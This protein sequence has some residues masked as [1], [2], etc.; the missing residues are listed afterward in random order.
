M[1]GY[2]KGVVEFNN[3][4]ISVEVKSLNSKQ[5]D[6]SLKMPAIYR[7]KEFEIR[8][9]ITK[10]LVRG[11]VE[12]YINIELLDQKQAL[13]INKELFEDYYLQLSSIS[14][15]INRN[16][17]FMQAILTLPGVLQNDRKDVEDAEWEALDKAVNIAIEEIDKFRIQE[18]NI[19]IR[20]MLKRISIIRTLKTSVEPFE[21]ERIE[22]I[23]RRIREN[24]EKLV[25]DFDNNRLEQEMI[26]Y[27][28][29]LDI[30]EEK[31][32]LEN[33]L[34]YFENICSGE[35]NVGRK[36]GFVAQEIGREINTMGSKSNNSDMQKIVVGMKDELE[37]IKE[38]SLNIL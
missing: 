5:L 1:T 9:K 12:V 11:K 26:Y 3:R 36:L 34:N 22:L 33:H 37:K 7:D 15:D 2:G 20:D 14:S 29:K 38:Q 23:K 19:L 25:G 24:M 6:C 28:E 32:R 10:A 31:V 35:D 13:P 17:D 4:R 16:A 27:I 8:S 18:G 30:T 21:K